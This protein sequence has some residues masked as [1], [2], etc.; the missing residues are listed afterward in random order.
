[1]LPET[2][3]GHDK[4][5]GNACS[6]LHA[7]PGEQGLYTSVSPHLSGRAWSGDSERAAT[8]T[9]LIAAH[10]SVAA[11]LSSGGIPPHRVQSTP[12]SSARNPN[13]KHPKLKDLALIRAVTRSSTQRSRTQHNLSIS[14]RDFYRTTSV[15]PWVDMDVYDEKSKMQEYVHAISVDIINSYPGTQQP[16]PLNQ[17]RVQ[18]EFHGNECQR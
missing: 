10:F 6:R 7:R 16:W 1:V 15:Y 18:R 4:L 13:W 11:N 17:R 3:L 9:S 5:C 8:S 12:L 2:R 14:N